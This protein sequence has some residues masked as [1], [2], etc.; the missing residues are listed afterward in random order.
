MTAR[1]N[2]SPPNAGHGAGAPCN[3]AVQ[4]CQ[5]APARPLTAAELQNDPASVMRWPRPGRIRNRTMPR[6]GMKKAGGSTWTR[7]RVQFQFGVKTLAKGLGLISLSLQRLL[8]L[9]WWESS[10]HIRILPPKAGSRAQAVKI[11]RLMRHTACRT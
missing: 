7:R 1:R 6:T 10:I 11:E 9:S 4:P 2:P 3:G 8:A 5:Q